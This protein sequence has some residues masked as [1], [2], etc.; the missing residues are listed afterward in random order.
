MAD[1]TAIEAQ[2]NKYND[3]LAKFKKYAQDNNLSGV[4]KGK[5]DALD[6]EEA[7]AT[8]KANATID[9]AKAVR[10]TVTKD[11]TDP[12]GAILK[13]DK[14]IKDETQDSAAEEQQILATQATINTEIAAQEDKLRETHA[15]IQLLEESNAQELNELT[16]VH[17]AASQMHAQEVVELKTQS[18]NAQAEIEQ[19]R[20][21]CALEEKEFHDTE[22]QLDDDHHQ[23]KTELLNEVRAN[24]ELMR[25]A[26]GNAAQKELEHQAAKKII[27]DECAVLQA[28]IDEKQAIHESACRDQN[29]RATQQA[30]RIRILKEFPR[31]IADYKRSEDEIVSYEYSC[32]ETEQ[33]VSDL[34][35]KH[36]LGTS[37]HKERLFFLEKEL[38]RARSHNYRISNRI[39]YSL[40]DPMGI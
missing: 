27:E 16:Q 35:R 18:M 6:A 38:E 32:M 3:Q 14:A 29:V 24:E 30:E 19:T 20:Q 7:A 36:Y 39:A 8:Q 31:M 9:A 11:K 12:D 2:R 28:G 13:L 25:D 22:I 5:L 15:D 37:T 33:R 17:E 4:F 40:R 26:Q 10:E 34:R 21:A 1:I 23:R